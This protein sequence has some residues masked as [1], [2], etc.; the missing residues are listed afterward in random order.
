MKAKFIEWL[1]TN[2][3]III[4]VVILLVILVT[5]IYLIKSKINFMTN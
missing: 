4:M 5:C 2:I 3:V 1:K